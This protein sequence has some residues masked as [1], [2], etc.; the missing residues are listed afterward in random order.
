[1]VAARLPMIS[2]RDDAIAFDEDSSNSGIR[3]RFSQ[4]FLR[5]GEGDS[6]EFFVRVLWR[7]ELKV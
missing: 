3:P 2:A 6:H 5:F 4:P 1:M 7:H